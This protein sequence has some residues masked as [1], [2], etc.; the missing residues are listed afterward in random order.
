MFGMDKNKWT[1]ERK[2]EDNI[3]IMFL[4]TK[5]KEQKKWMNS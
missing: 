1:K 5:N 3:Y 4:D 2:I